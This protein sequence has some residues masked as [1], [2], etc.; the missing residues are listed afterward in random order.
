MF[1]E[2]VIKWSK[3]VMIELVIKWSKIVMKG[4]KR[5]L[6]HKFVGHAKYVTLVLL[7]FC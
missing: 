7:L 5:L 4:C 3:I 1:I 6:S 2:L